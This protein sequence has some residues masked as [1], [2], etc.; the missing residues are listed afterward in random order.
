[1]KSK[2][3]IGALVI[4]IILLVSYTYN[5]NKPSGII[6]NA[7]VDSTICLDRDKLQRANIK[8]PVFIDINGNEVIPAGKFTFIGKFAPNGLARVKTD[9]SLSGKRYGYI[10]TCGTFVFPIQFYEASDFSDQG[11]ASVIYQSTGSWFTRKRKG[12]YID[13]YGTIH[14]KNNKNNAHN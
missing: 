5:K 11:L 12:A 7:H 1:M 2:L 14:I 10:N 13:K 4:S 6:Y 9:Y 8:Q 3:V